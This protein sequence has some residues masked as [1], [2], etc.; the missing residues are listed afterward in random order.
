MDT[1]KFADSFPSPEARRRWLMRPI[2][3]RTVPACP[4]GGVLITMPDI[5]NREE[6]RGTG[7][8]EDEEWGSIGNTRKTVEGA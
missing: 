7:F 2:I 3:T 1:T 6:R 5:R 8:V 4:W